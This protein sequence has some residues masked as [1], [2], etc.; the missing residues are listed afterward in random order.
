M[1][2]AAALLWYSRGEIS[3][4]VGA[5]IADVSHAEFI[6]KLSRRRISVWGEWAFARVVDH[7]AVKGSDDSS[8]RA[9]APAVHIGLDA[10]VRDTNASSSLGFFGETTHAAP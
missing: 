6:D 10:K 1:R 9:R 2:L 4:S 5:A 3:Q 8:I 7:T